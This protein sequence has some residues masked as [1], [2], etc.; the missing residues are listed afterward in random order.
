LFKIGDFSKLAQVSVKTL[1]YYAQLGL[2]E[3]VWVD[4]FSGYRYYTLEQLPRLN[5]VLALKDLGFSLEQVQQ[6]LQDNLAASEL[7]GVLRL[8]QAEL[9]RQ[10]QDEQM[11]LKRIQAR[12]RQIDQEGRLPAY[13]VV[14]KQTAS[15]RVAGIREVVADIYRVHSL[16]SRLQ[17]ALGAQGTGLGVTHAPLAAPLAIYYDADYHERDIDVE[18][19]LPVFRNLRVSDCLVL[20]ELPAVE[21]MACAVH[22][23]I[24]EGLADASRALLTWVEENGYR[25]AGPSRDVYLQNPLLDKPVESPVAEV[26]LPVQ[27]KPIPI[28]ITYQKEKN[29][30]EPKIVT[31]PAF[32]AVGMFYKGKNENQEIGQLWGKFN[33]RMSEIKNITDGCFG[34]CK[35]SDESGVFQYLACMAVTECKEAPQGMEVWEVPE[36]KY[37]VFPCTL[38]TIHDAYRYAFETWLPQS[39]YEYSR[40]IDFEYYD[41]SFDPNNKD[42]QLY[43]YIPLK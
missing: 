1:R 20:H 38:P 28:F 21:S 23:G 8:K 31:K 17:G 43:I 37:V 42:S 11:R 14:L 41:E 25:V 3:P 16:F 32:K 30:M 24:P 5:R 19:A 26:Q 18:A 36:Q 13:D 15:Q 22:Q 33:P 2:L 39:V 4:R 40:G 29:K 9:E 34:L 27:K 12:L 10:L 35:P 6:M 7:C